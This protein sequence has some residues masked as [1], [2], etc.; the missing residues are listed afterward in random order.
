MTPRRPAAR[1]LLAA[2]ATAVSAAALAAGCGGKGAFRLTAVDNDPGRLEA[3]FARMAPPSA[4]PINRTGKPLAFLVA[5]GRAGATELVAFDLAGKKELWRTPAAVSSRIVVGAGFVAHGEDGGLV[6]RDL[7]T[8]RVLWRHRVEGRLVGAAADERRVFYSAG[9]ASRWH[10]TALDGTSGDELWREEATGAL[11][12]PAARGGLVFSPFLKQWLTILDAATGEPLARIRG[13][14]EAITFV[15][16]TGER[17]FFGSGVGVFLLDRRA[18][19][20]ERARSTY[21][22]AD[23]PG[24]FVRVHYGHD[25]YDPVQGGYSAYDRN[26]LLWRAHADG[27]ALRFDDDRVVVHTYRYFFGFDAR[28]GALT[29]AYS[30]PRHDVV[31]SDHLGPVIGFAASQGG[32]GALDPATGRVVYRAEVRGQI[33][34]ATFDAGGWAPAEDHGE[35]PST[36]AVLAGIANDRDARFE[37]VKR[38]AVAALARLEGPEVTGDLIAL[39]Q[40]D[41]TPPALYEAAVEALVARRDPA[42]LAALV[43]ALE[44]QHD[45]LAGTAP[46]A[47]GVLA[48]AIAALP[49]AELDPAQR[50]RAVDALIGHLRA[51][52]T[53]AADLEGVVA[54]LGAIGAGAERDP[55]RVFL[56]LYR[57]DPSFSTQVGAV[58]GAVDVLLARGGPAERELVTFVV[59]DARTQPAV[60]EYASRALLQSTT[61]A[62]P[63]PPPPAP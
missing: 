1:A 13:I 56:L 4:G 14:D 21:G 9:E 6:G 3:A 19:S 41:K 7:T 39:V 61:S 25:A 37:D 43:A 55:L 50:G 16:A 15:R 33:V 57:A 40:G 58:G 10:L 63:P 62:P 60:R 54:A 36:A 30:H 17:V 35:P 51:P 24:E 12:A 38:F 44:V 49:V 42:G 26:R 46:G 28:T 27:D 11:G 45:H 47:V 5:R 32:L 29:W 34:G 53:P 18:A 59:E 48:R 20:G 2:A 22:A 31:G 8:G 52:E 23:L